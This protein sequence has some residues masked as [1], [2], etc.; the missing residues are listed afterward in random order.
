MPKGRHR[1]QQLT[2]LPAGARTTTGK[3]Q[4]EN[5]AKTYQRLLP[6]AVEA[7]ETPAPGRHFAAKTKRGAVPAYSEQP[8]VFPAWADYILSK[9]GFPGATSLQ[10]KQKEREMECVTGKWDPL[11]RSVYLEVTR[12][13]SSPSQSTENDEDQ[14]SSSM[15]Y[16]WESGFFGKGTLSRSEPT[17]HKRQVNA[18]RVKRERERG[19]KGESRVC[20]S[21]RSAT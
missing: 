21:V 2:Q 18:I 10:A 5:K 9:C 16:L 15:R 1:K 3:A 19:G 4:T 12:P 13:S 11:S 8:Y 6:V 17:W 7:N 20:D 14:Q